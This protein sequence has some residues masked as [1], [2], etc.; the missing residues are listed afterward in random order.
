MP[1]LRAYQ[2]SFTAGALAPSL[3]ARVDLAKYNTGLKTA[4]NVFIHPHGGASNR[5]GLEFIREV[6]NSANF[7]RLIPFQFNTE[8]SYELEFGHNYFRVFRDGGVILSGAVPYEVVTPYAHNHVADL[9]FIQEAD[10]MYICHPEYPVRKL[11][12]LA[13]NNWTLTVVTFAPSQ[14]APGAPVASTPGSTVGRPG[15]TAT[16]YTYR[17][18]AISGETGE[19]S[20]PSPPSNTV[21]NDLTIDGGINRITWTAVAGA[22]RYIIYKL[23][24]G[25]YG[26]IGGT[27]GLS[28]DDQNIVPDLAD[29]PQ[30]ARNPFNSAG[31]YP[32]CAT[33]IEQRLAF[34]ST[35][36]DP[37][38]VWMSQPA[39]YENFGYSS[40]SK[41]SDAVTFRI[42]ARQVNEIRSMLAVKG[43]MLLSSGAEWIVSGGSQSDAITPSSIKIDNQGYRGAATVQPVV[44]GNTVLFAQDRGG[45]I[46][47]FS[48]EFAQDSFTGK[49]LTVLARHLFENK[50]IK[51]WAYAQAPH[52]IMWV[53]LDDGSLVSLT[54]MKE[55]D[56]WGWT[57]HESAGAIF[58]DVSVIAE[59]QEDVPYFIVR[60]TINGQ[61][62][63]YIER[64]HSRWFEAIEDAFFVDCGLTYEGPPIATLTGLGHLEGQA[65]VALADGNVMRSLTVTGGAVTLQ[66]PASK[67]H[68]GLPMVAA[69][70]TLDLDLGN[71]AGLGTIQGRKKSVS[72][73][74]MRVENTRGIFIGPRDGDRDDRHLVE[75]KQRST[76]NWNAAIQTFTGDIQMTSQWDW[77][78]GGNMWIK[79]FDPLPMTILAAMPDITLGG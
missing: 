38:A 49:D 2:P 15:Y 53:I 24:N 72:G 8:Q 59:G 9:V 66:N 30:S 13:D 16:T 74:T 65:V 46:R 4:L 73:F 79:Q 14:A 41:A 68:I 77:T 3:W 17:V 11:A 57:H 44:V 42:K 12:R 62:K 29:T 60:R 34:A 43:L 54:Y 5:P 20:L 31:N 36:N 63:R 39:N 26:Y 7:A 32:R 25:I 45:V 50:S 27:S 48:Y 70:Q 19:E 76:E 78:D 51:A 55:H 6:K 75:Y 52:S 47:D 71:V 35:N 37:Q 28:F 21:T 1:E 40:P 69:L 18:A 22:G 10:V 56:V 23:D 33:F 61:T 67:I 64:L 58:E